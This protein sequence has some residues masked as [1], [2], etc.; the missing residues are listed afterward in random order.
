LTFSLCRQITIEDCKFD[1]NTARNGGGGFYNYHQGTFEEVVT[2]S[3]LNSVFQDNTNG[4]GGISGPRDFKAFEMIFSGN[5]GTNSFS[6][7]GC[8]GFDLGVF[9]EDGTTTNICPAVD[10]EFVY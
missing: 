6:R 2:F 4:A 1:A 7:N 10:E 8:A 5:S 3:I 9:Q